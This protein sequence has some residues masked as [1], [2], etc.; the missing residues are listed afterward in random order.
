MNTFQETY[1]TPQQFAKR[2]SISRWTVYAWLSEGRIESVKIGRLVRI[3]E[4]ELQ[5]IISEGRQRVVGQ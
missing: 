2:L 4:T 1:L 3:P 5:R